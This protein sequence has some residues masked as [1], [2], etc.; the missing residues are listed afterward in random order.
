MTTLA[1]TG[2]AG[3][4]NGGPG[5]AA[6]SNPSGIAV[7]ANGNVYVS[8]HLN[9]RIRLI[10]PNGT[11]VTFAG[12]G[13]AAWADGA[14]SG[15]S[16]RNP[17]LLAIDAESSLFVGEEGNFDVRKVTAAGHVSTV[18]GGPASSYIDGYGTA[19][20]FR[21]PFGVAVGPRGSLFIG[22]YS[23]NRIRQVAC[24]PCPASFYCFSGSPVVC[25]P[26]SFCPL[27]SINATLCP[28]GSF[29][30]AGASTCT[31]CPA[32]T[33]AAAAGAASCQQC[34]SGHF[35]PTGA[36]SWAHHNCG[37]GNYCPDGAG[38]PTP[39]PYQAPPLGGWGDLQAQGPAFLVETAHCL[40]HCFWNFSS[41]DGALSK[42]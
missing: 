6:F 8:D 39:C 29:S 21:L 37:R 15:A 34:T 22:D 5:V 33:F 19:A 7:A 35:C 42:C 30:A 10:F 4:S 1:G 23:G 20:R 40:N 36:S 11:V 16:F 38:A 25:P 24:V 32:G 14:G 9:H 12:S 31:L 3:A 13:S 26:G 18:A 27:S 28:R 2:A 17:R 41:G